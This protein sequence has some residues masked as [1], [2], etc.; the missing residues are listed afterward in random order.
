MGQRSIAGGKTLPEQT[1]DKIRQYIKENQLKPGAKL[2]NEFQLG[3]LCGVGRSTVREAIKLLVFEGLVE[4]VRGNGTYLLEQ[5]GEKCPEDPMGLRGD[6]NPAQKALQFLEVRLILEPEI[7]AMA[8]AN[9]DYEDCRRLRELKDQVE[10]CILAGEDYLQPDIQ[11]HTQIAKC[12]RNE[13]VYKLM[14]IV[15][16]GIPAF[17]EVTKNSLTDATIHFHNEITEAICR[18][19]VVG[20]RCGM[21][22]HLSYNR[23]MIL[24]E[25]DSE[26]QTKMENH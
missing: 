24:N 1:A 18:G 2:P 25:A 7:A 3:Q 5:K 15:V 4:V 14:E 22:G 11:F 19:D 26:T 10:R 17:I 12:S 16:T 20:A 8:A 9:A 6:S 21:I 13:V 23:R